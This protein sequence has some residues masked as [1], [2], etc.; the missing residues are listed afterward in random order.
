MPCRI[1]ESTGALMRFEKVG[2]DRVCE[3][4]RYGRSQRLNFEVSVASRKISQFWTSL[5][6]LEHVN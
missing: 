5:K 6:S 2:T 1:D 3:E 4:G